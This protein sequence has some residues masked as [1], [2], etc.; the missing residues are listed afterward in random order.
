MK[1]IK[2]L[3]VLEAIDVLE[4]LGA[5]YDPIIFRGKENTPVG[6]AGRDD[7]F[8]GR[9]LYDPSITISA[10]DVRITFF[11]KKRKKMVK[12][13]LYTMVVCRLTER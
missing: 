12:G 4:A 9:S 5:G 2:K 11:S 7:L 13:S 1:K 6:I 3:N 8:N 10:S